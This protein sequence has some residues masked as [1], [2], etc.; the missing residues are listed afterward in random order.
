MIFTY[1]FDNIYNAFI[2]LFVISTYDGWNEIMSVGVNSDLEI[3]VFLYLR[4]KIT[5]FKR[6]HISLIINIHHIAFF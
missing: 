5:I 3:N 4:Y 6:G 1:N 2:T